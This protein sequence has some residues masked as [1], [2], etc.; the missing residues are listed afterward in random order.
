MRANEECYDFSGR[1]HL[2]CLLQLSS[3]FKRRTGHYSNTDVATIMM[4]RAQ[5]LNVFFSKTATARR[6][7]KKY[8]SGCALIAYIH[9]SQ[10]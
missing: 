1:R 9:V 2:S 5:D 7:L 3:T 10:L 8:R 4:A 6:R